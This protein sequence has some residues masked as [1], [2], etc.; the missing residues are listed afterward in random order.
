M[1]KAILFVGAGGFAGS[2]LRYL[3]QWII[4]K[5]IT[6]PFPWPTFVVNILGSFIIGVLYALSDKGHILSPEL[7]LLLA[8]GFCGGF[9]TFSFFAF[10]N[11]SLLHDG[12]VGF[13][14]LYILMSVVLGILAAYMG[15]LL[16]RQW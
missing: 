10:D 1:M 4:S 15:V 16:V 6:T 13:S 5:S 7:R 3:L 9:T 12:Q 2:I 8:T 14:F 11:V